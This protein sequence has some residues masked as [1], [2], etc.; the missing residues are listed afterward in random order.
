MLIPKATYRIQ[1]HPG[2]GFADA[3]Q[4]VLYLQELGV[5]H[6]YAS[7]IFK[8]RRGSLHG[9]DVVDPNR[10][11]PE[12]GGFSD[13][14]RLIFELQDRGI[15]WIQDI[16][17]N[18]MAFNAENPFLMDVLET[19]CDS[20]YCNF[21]DIDWE[22]SFQSIKGR[23][24]APFLGR[25]YGESL[26]SGE[27]AL[28]FGSEGM[29][30]TYYNLAF[31][32][33]MDSYF[34]FFTHRLPALKKK[35]GEDHPDYIKLLGVLYVLKTNPHDEESSEPYDQRKFVKR[36][37]WEL[38]NRNEDVKDFVDTNILIFNGTPGQGESF[39]LLDDVLSQQL[40]R[41]S[42][43]KVAAEEINYR[44]F[45]SI[46]DLISLKVEHGEVFNHVHR[47]TFDLVD[48]DMISGLRVDHVDGL[49]DPALY[50][51]RLREHAPESYIVVEKILELDEDLPSDWPVQGTTGYEF[52]N[53]VNGIF[54]DTENEKA[55][56]KVYSGV[57]S[58]KGSY[59]ELVRKNKRVIV[60]EDMAGD[61][62]N[63]AQL[64]KGIAGRD[65]HGSDLTLYGLQ[66][67]LKEVLVAFPV[68]R[69][70]VSPQSFTEGD[71]DYIE[72]AIRTVTGRNPAMVN[73]LSFIKRFLL[74]E[75]P[76]YVSDDEREQ[77]LRFSMRFQQ[78]TGPLM[79]KGFE[80]T[81]LYEYNRLVSLNEVGGNP[82]RF[83]ATVEEFHRFNGKRQWTWPHSLNATATH[84]TKRGEDVRARINVLS[85]IPQEWERTF[86]RWNG[87]NRRKKKRISGINVPDRNDE[88]F[89][90]Q[91][92]LGA[93]PFDTA[94]YPD[95]VE[96]MKAYVIKAVREAKVHTAWLKP[97]TDYEEAF[98]SFV[99]AVL[100]PSERNAF[101]K[102]FAPLQ[103][104]VAHHGALNSLAQTLLKITSPGVPDFYQGTE[105]WDLS[106]VDP[107]NRRPVDFD[108]RISYLREIGAKAESDLWGYASELL[109]V[110]DDG[111]VKLFLIHRA[112]A[113]R[114]CR[115]EVFERGE[116]L[117]LGIEG[118]FAR[119]VV[120]FARRYQ[121]VWA[122]VAVPRFTTRLVDETHAPIGPRVWQDTQ[123]ILPREAPECWTDALTG[124]QMEAKA[125]LA[126]GEVLNAF[127]AALLF[128][129][130]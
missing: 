62:Y 50:L 82:S 34:S 75:F 25:S 115:P 31:P 83:G 36:M 42:F 3:Q 80:D 54:C 88:Y 69:T 70:Y 6:V 109:A 59:E 21:F 122:V 78:F 94:D 104:K 5:S 45:F 57:G 30:V 123:I 89:F 84:D 39:T 76:D 32:L 87:L 77:W 66:R 35:L 2:F 23:L 61:V 27:I 49:Y 96:R 108:K 126:V 129:G 92:L 128:G 51:R 15:G 26:E 95:F 41:L 28:S 63:L 81:T 97:D 20:Q 130:D 14:E 79:A 60:E 85:E 91:N 18:H 101:L 73:E 121:S 10:I 116:Y 111:R 118:K 106:L 1:F 12:L 4:I 93:F 29:K 98:V 9:Y 74:L 125:S 67:A 103:A 17:P 56:S 127:P 24:L 102:E 100:D 99:D 55:F 90:Y 107:D 37:L 65:R 8:A 71:R 13:L 112:L 68:Y 110:K 7:P 113:A 117:P 72:H 52:C 120:A 58:F 22:Q 124:L 119:H 53:K 43:W 38:Y 11:N 19:G 86:R 16:V 33:R 46:N 44:R 40:F 64:A 105:L 48:R 114:N 47:L